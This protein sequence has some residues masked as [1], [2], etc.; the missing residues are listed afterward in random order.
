MIVVGVL[1]VSSFN[2]HFLLRNKCVFDDILHT[3]SITQNLQ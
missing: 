3:T 1:N 2:N